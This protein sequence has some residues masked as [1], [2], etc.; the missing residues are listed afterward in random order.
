[1]PAVCRGGV[2]KHNCK[3]LDESDSNVYVNGS[4]V[5]RVSDGHDHGSTQTDGS[6]NVFANGLAV[7]RIG[8][9]HGGCPIPCPPN[10][11]ATGSPNVF[12]N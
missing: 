2:D 12:A 11:E 8:D 9:D 7:A 5:H 10:P 1:M 4:P 6:P 3:A